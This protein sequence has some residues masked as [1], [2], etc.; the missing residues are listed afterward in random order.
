M[1]QGGFRDLQIMETALDH[2][3][4]YD[5]QAYGQTNTGHPFGDALTQ[6]ERRAIIEFLKFLSGPNM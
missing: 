2:M 5:T 6:Q 3:F 4:I 1:R